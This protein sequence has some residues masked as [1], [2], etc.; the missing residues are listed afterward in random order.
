VSCLL[1]RNGCSTV[2]TS[3]NGGAGGGLDVTK[4]FSLGLDAGFTY[5]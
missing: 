4:I 5:S 2:G 1:T 3:V